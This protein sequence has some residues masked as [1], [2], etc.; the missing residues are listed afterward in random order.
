MSIT[1]KHY[2]LGTGKSSKNRGKYYLCQNKTTNAAYGCVIYPAYRD[3][4]GRE[5][6]FDTRHDLV[7]L[8]LSNNDDNLT[9][10]EE[11]EALDSPC[12]LGLAKKKGI[13]VTMAMAMEKEA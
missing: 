7:L 11:K 10:E 5:L 3:P 1:G 6:I 13:N 12:I 8:G 2:H 4:E 9:L